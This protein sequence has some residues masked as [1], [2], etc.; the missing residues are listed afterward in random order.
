MTDIVDKLEA[1]MSQD[2]APS[3]I[4]AWSLF[5][6]NIPVF[7]DTVIYRMLHNPRIRMGLRFKKGPILSETR[8]EV[9]C[10]N[11]E[12]KQFLEDELERFM[13]VGME[14]A[15]HHLDWGSC[16]CEVVYCQDPLTQR[17]HFDKLIYLHK[18][19]VVPQVLHNKVVGV[20]L[21]MTSGEL[22]TVTSPTIYIGGMKKLW[23]VH[24]RD[25]HPIWGRSDLYGAHTPWEEFDGFGGAREA[26]SIWFRKN[27]FD[28][29]SLRFP[30]RQ[31]NVDG[32]MVHNRL[33][34]QSILDRRRTGGTLAL[35]A[36]PVDQPQWEY[37]GPES[38]EAPT[39]MMDYIRILKEEELEGMEIPPELLASSEEGTSN[40]K[41]VLQQ[42]FYTSLTLIA[43]ECIFA[44]SEQVL[45]SLVRFNF[46]MDVPFDIKKIK[47]QNDQD[48]MQ[49]QNQMG[50][51]PGEEQ[52]DEN[53]DPIKA[54]NNP[55][56]NGQETTNQSD[57]SKANPFAK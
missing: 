48:Q 11:A 5:P 14:T 4:P 40:N 55:F 6:G 42:A 3:W 47:V 37:K 36:E 18:T 12:V 25:F 1:N 29:G 10:D 38:A 24:D 44:F 52:V 15:L 16:A 13:Q 9:D 22:Y 56:S 50:G 49:L 41:R 8:Y 33:I 7:D 39:T 31:S 17:M 32:R 53:G 35:P 26:R 51:L 45:E 57:S 23:I 20:N 30:N 2:Y 34:A 19:S 28:G 27:A 21:K 43:Q 54:D 46:G